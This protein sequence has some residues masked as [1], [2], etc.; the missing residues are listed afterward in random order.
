MILGARSLV[1]NAIVVHNMTESQEKKINIEDLDIETV[2]DMFKY[3]Y[4]G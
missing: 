1:I 3:I 4:A 2:K